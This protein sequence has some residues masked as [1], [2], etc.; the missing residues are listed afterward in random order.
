MMKIKE[1]KKHMCRNESKNENKITSKEKT[2]MKMHDNS[3][4]ENCKN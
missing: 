2:K 1:I 3:Y 4:D